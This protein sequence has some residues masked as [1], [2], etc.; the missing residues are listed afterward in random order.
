MMLFGARDGSVDHH[1]SGFTLVELLIFSFFSVIILAIAGGMLISSLNVETTTRGSL[2]R[3]NLDQLITR[4]V[5]TGVR[6][7]SDFQI[8]PLTV[9]GQLMR[10]RVAV[11]TK[12]GTVTWECQAWY[13]SSVTKG[14][15]WARSATG[16]V[17]G[18]VK[19]ADLRAS[20]WLLVGEGLYLDASNGFFGSDSSNAWLRFKFSPDKKAP[21][22]VRNTTIKPKSASPEVEPKKCFD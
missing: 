8:K 3:S 9:D 5:D 12:A 14:F 19:A 18:P 17:P 7:A 11:G 2:E 10:A 22:V 16:L 13:Y 15:Y 4:T 21:V 6:S 1:D 20:P